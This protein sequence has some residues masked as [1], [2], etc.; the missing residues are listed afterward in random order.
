MEASTE[1]PLTTAFNATHNSTSLDS[2]TSSPHS[3]VF[4]LA[5]LIIILLI[6]VLITFLA[7][8]RAVRRYLASY[9]HTRLQ[10]A[11]A[12]SQP[13]GLDVAFTMHAGN[14]PPPVLEEDDDG[15]IEDNYIQAVDRER[16]QRAAQTLEDSEDEMEDIE[17]SIA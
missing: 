4:R 13:S 12:V 6:A 11:D 5:V 10:E 9:R 7:K 2:D 15:F 16:A 3:W 17:F 8:C 1:G 14:Y